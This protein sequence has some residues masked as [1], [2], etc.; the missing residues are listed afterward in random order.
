[1]ASVEGSSG[2]FGA[3]PLFAGTLLI[4]AIAM[5]VAVPVVIVPTP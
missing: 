5:L 1:M 4:T 3:V 2:T